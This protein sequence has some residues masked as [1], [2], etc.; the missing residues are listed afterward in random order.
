MIK[1]FELTHPNCTVVFTF[2]QSSAHEGFA[3]DALN[4]NKINVQP[5]C[6]HSKLCDTIIPFS[7]PDPV[8]DEEDMCSQFQH[9]CFPVYHSDLD[10]WD[11]PKGI[12]VVLEE[13]KSVWDKFTM[14]CREHG[15]K[16][17]GKCGVC[18]K[19]DACKDKEQHIAL[20]EAMEQGDVPLMEEKPSYVANKWCCMHKVLLLQEDFWSEKPLIQ[21]IIED[22]RH[23]CLFLLW[24]HCE[25]NAIEMLWGYRKYCAHISLM[26]A[27]HLSYIRLQAIETWL[28]EGLLPWGF[29]SLSALIHAVLPQSGGSSRKPG[30][31]LMHTRKGLIQQAAFANRKY[32]SHWRISLPSDILTSLAT[33]DI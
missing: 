26:S 6:K 3:E 16:I 29:W 18:T 5:T 10:L 33:V 7:N 22:A 21:S 17:V 13:H 11:K 20:A 32:K 9:M 27:M 25:L 14:V 31:T 19:S 30:D 15:K 2:D 1:I 28:M 4:V 12:K 8:P 24:F 23:I